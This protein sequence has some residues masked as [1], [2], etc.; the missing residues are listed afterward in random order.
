MK[1]IWK[2]IEKESEE[3]ERNVIVS[4]KQEHSTIQKAENKKE[5]MGIKYIMQKFKSE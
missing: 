1:T 5:P 3:T 2:N 4:L